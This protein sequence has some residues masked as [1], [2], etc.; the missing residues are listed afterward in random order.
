MELLAQFTNCM[1][2]SSLSSFFYFGL[3]LCHVRIYKFQNFIYLFTR[4][5]LETTLHVP[6]GGL[7]AHAGEWQSGESGIY[8]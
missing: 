3:K 1:M 8:S 2:W 5:H 4:E 6:G 7:P